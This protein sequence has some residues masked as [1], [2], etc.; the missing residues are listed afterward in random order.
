MGSEARFWTRRMRWRL[1]GAWQWPA[2]ALLT[3]IDGLILHLIWPGLALIPGLIVASFANLVLVGVIAP[4]LARRLAARDRAARGVTG[5]AGPPLEVL[6]DR[7]ATWLLGAGG[8]A[9]LVTAVA[10]QPLIVSETDATEENARLVHDYVVA[11]ATP[12]VKRNL[13]TANTIRLGE[14]YFRTCV[15]LDDP[16]NAY[17]LFVETNADP[18]S[19]VED[20][21]PVPNARFPGVRD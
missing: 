18:A 13:S 2:F 8:I 4:W 20:P 21:N 1:R 16:T 9:L 19:V 15:A 11:N 12:E 6:A 3:V 14:G 7:S 17:C 10:A 5:V